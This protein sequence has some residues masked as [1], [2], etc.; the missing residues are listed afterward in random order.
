[1]LRCQHFEL[2][3]KRKVTCKPHLT[4]SHLCDCFN[5]GERVLSGVE[6]FESHH[7][8]DPSL[9]PS[10]ALLNDVIH[11]FVMPRNNRDILTFINVFDCRHISSALINVY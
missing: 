8:P 4:F 7:Q 5:T 3:F 6:G 10:M 11:V 1:V 9:N 2:P